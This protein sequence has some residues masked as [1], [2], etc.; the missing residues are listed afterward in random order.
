VLGLLFGTHHPLAAGALAGLPVTALSQLVLFAYQEIRPDQDN[1]HE[2]SYTPDDRDEAEHARNAILKALFDKEGPAAYEAMIR[3]ARHR[4]IKARR[5]RFRE[6]AR[7]MGERDADVTAWQPAE[8]LSFERDKTLPVKSAPQLYKLVQALIK[9][10]GSEFDNADASARALLETARDENAVQE[11]LAAEMKHRAKNRY[12]VSRESEVAEG[13]MPD[14]LVSG[15]GALVEVAVEAKHGGKEWSTNSLEQ[16]LRGQLAEDY[17]RPTTRRHGVFVVTNHR[18]RGW[19]HPVT[20]KH[21][22]FAE[23]IDYLYGIAATLRRNSVGEIAVTVIGIDA[24]K[25]PRKR[26][27]GSANRTPVRKKATKNPATRRGKSA[28]RPLR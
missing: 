3:L 27:V 25:K 24:L 16:S 23:M 11:W 19:T 28:R 15:I 17:L 4:D 26:A 18:N 12:H 7:R 10:I 21:L 8:V 2:G 22:S 5:I 1:V 9:E 13:N 14:I 20:R 6:L